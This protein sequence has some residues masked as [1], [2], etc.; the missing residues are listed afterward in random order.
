MAEQKQVSVPTINCLLDDCKFGRRLIQLQIPVKAGWWN[1][2]DSKLNVT[3]SGNRQVI[4]QRFALVDPTLKNKLVH[5]HVFIP[6]Q[7]I[8]EL[9][10]KTGTTELN[11]KLDMPDRLFE[12]DMLLII[13]FL[14]Q[15]DTCEL[16]LE[17]KDGKTRTV[18]AE[19]YNVVKTLKWWESTT[20]A[21]CTVVQASDKSFVTLS[22]EELVMILLGHPTPNPKKGKLPKPDRYLA[23]AS[24]QH[25]YKM[26]AG[27]Y[28]LNI[29]VV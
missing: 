18:D 24:A 17:S 22:L 23:K 12:R 27:F 15:P 21:A 11:P 26:K 10:A 20:G 1:F 14:C 13:D 7:N 8:T 28:A 4:L 9:C 16:K 3:Y 25:D 2:R 5:D 6:K 29:K 19:D